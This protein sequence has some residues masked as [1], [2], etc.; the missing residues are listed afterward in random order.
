MDVKNEF[1]ASIAESLL[2]RQSR[3]N[4]F[5]VVRGICANFVSAGHLHIQSQSPWRGLCAGYE[6]SDDVYERGRQSSMQLVAIFW[7]VIQYQEWR[8]KTLI[9]RW[10]SG[11]E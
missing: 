9:R 7:L 11:P 4:D 8:P 2:D 5:R 6:G 3:A 10:Q 1:G